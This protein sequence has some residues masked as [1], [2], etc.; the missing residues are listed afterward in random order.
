MHPAD[1]LSIARTPSATARW[2]CLGPDERGCGVQVTDG[3]PSR[4]LLY[5]RE[6][7]SA[8]LISLS[9]DYGWE[10]VLTSLP[11]DP[12]ASN[13]P[14]HLG[15]ATPSLTHRSLGYRLP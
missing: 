6:R 9:N 1:A 7:C 10:R 2:V 11:V 4:R 3:C 13:E 15:S 8:P 14:V 5:C 12:V